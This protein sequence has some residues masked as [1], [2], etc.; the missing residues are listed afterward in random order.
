MIVE[1][2]WFHIVKST[3]RNIFILTKTIIQKSKY[4]LTLTIYTS[5]K[6]VKLIIKLSDFAK[7]YVHQR[8]E[9]VCI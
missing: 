3:L 5:V 1:Q 9:I 4:S 6:F 2:F 8:P 7:L